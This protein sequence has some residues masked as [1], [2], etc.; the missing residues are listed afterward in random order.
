MRLSSYA[1]YAQNAQIHFRPC[2]GFVIV[3]CACARVDVLQE[4][5]T[6]RT[7]TIFISKPNTLPSCRG[8]IQKEISFMTWTV[9]TGSLSIAQIHVYLNLLAINSTLIIIIYIKSKIIFM[10]YFVENY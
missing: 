7:V 6:S 1:E 10:L 3:L 8:A 9:K 2:S 4:Q 5:T